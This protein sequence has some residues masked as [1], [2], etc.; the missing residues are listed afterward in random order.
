MTGKEPTSECTAIN[1][2]EGGLKKLPTHSFPPRP[3]LTARNMGDHGHGEYK[4]P[5]L[6]TQQEMAAAK[7]DVAWRDSCASL[8]IPLNE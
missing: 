5:R 8:L 4:M 3:D 2:I 7:L 1:R 6:A